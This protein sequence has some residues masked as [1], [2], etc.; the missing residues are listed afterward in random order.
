MADTMPCGVSSNSLNTGL[1]MAFPAVDVIV[2]KPAL[3]VTTKSVPEPPLF[4]LSNEFNCI[5]KSAAKLSKVA[6]AGEGEMVKGLPLTLTEKLCKSVV[7][8]KVNPETVPLLNTPPEAPA[9]L[10]DPVINLA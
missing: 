6:A 2:K 4:N 5:C 7:L 8:V 1:V 3:L 10:E 9:G